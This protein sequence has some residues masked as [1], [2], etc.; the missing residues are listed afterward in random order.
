MYEVAKRTAME[1]RD[2]LGSWFMKLFDRL[3]ADSHSDTLDDWVYNAVKRTFTKSF[4]LWGSEKKLRE[5]EYEKQKG[6][7]RMVLQYESREDN[8]YGVVTIPESP[9]D[10]SDI[11]YGL[12]SRLRMKREAFLKDWKANAE[13]VM[14]QYFEEHKKEFLE[15]PICY[16]GSGFRTKPFIL[17]S[18]RGG[19]EDSD[20]R[21]KLGVLTNLVDET[22]NRK[23]YFPCFWNSEEDL[24]AYVRI[25]NY[26]LHVERKILPDKTFQID[27]PDVK[28]SFE[29]VE[30]QNYDWANGLEIL[31]LRKEKDRDIRYRNFVSDLERAEWQFRLNKEGFEE[32]FAYI[33]IIYNKCAEYICKEA[34][35]QFAGELRIVGTCKQKVP[36]YDNS[37]MTCIEVVAIK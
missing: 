4:R 30:S 18:S 34:R 21:E 5:A 26:V 25:G 35:K 6:E 17:W 8:V 7:I 16:M 11:A 27:W 12:A 1:N 2:A 22:L 15:Y 32:I 20:M 3:V 36:F 10:K 19:N 29:L 33:P 24:T 37:E 9:Q 28:V 23:S 14:E 13:K 31:Q